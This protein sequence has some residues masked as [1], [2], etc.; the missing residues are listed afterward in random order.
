MVNKTIIALTTAIIATLGS[1]IYLY[2]GETI[3]DI[4]LTDSRGD[5]KN[6]C[7]EGKNLSTMNAKIVIKV[8]TESLGKDTA[9]LPINI[10]IVPY[11][12]RVIDVM[13]P[14]NMNVEKENTDHMESVM[15]AN[16]MN[17]GSM[18]METKTIDIGTVKNVLEDINVMEEI[19]GDLMNDFL[20]LFML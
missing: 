11:V 20:F 9:I 8:N 5:D 7:K 19:N 6:I 17:M 14:T 2:N 1:T 3:T 15:I 13:E 10:G 12:K 18:I 16:L 4:N